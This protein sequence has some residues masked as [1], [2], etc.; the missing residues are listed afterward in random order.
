M[1]PIYNPVED[2]G[3][4]IA[5][6]EHFA[7]LTVW[8]ADPKIIDHLR[9]IGMLVAQR[10]LTHTYPHC[11]RCKNPT[12]FR[13]T[14]QWFISL[15]TDGLR[16]RA[17]EAIRHKVRWVPPWGE[18]RIANMVATRPDWCISRQRVWG[19]PIVAFYC[20]G[21]GA[22]LLEEP[23]IAHV[24]DLMGAGEGADLW[25]TRE[26]KDLVPAGTTCPNCGGSAFRKESDILDV[27]F[28]SG[29]SHA[30]VLETRPD[31]HWPAEM[32]LEGSD[33]HRGWF[34]SS[35]LEAVGTRGAPP[36][37]EV[38]THGFL[39]DGE[40]RKMS[41]SLGNVI[42]PQDVI[43]KHGAE[44]LRLWVAAEDYTED[45]RLPEPE[46]MEQ[47]TEAYRRIR[48]TCRFLLGNLS[49][50][51][52]DHHRMPY[53][54]LEEL[55]RWALGRLGRLIAR[56]RR[57]YEG[58]QFH[59]VYHALSNFCA[60][61][62]S[63]LYLDILKDRLYTFAPNDPRRRAAQTACYEILVAVTRL[64]APILTFTAEE[65][66]GYIH[67]S[68]KPESVHLMTFPEDRGE[69]M[70]EGLEEEWER[71]LEVRREV[72]RA[73]EAG[74]QRKI[75]GSSLEARVFILRAPEEQWMPLLS[76]K[77]TAF[78]KM[79]FIVSDVRL[80]EAPPA[81]P[82]TRYESQDIPELVIEVVKA[83][84]AR[85]WRKC[86]RCWVWSERVG[87]DD[88]HPTLC[89]RCAPVVRAR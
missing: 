27:W 62:L 74:R 85:G 50:F 83:D 1:A 76:A 51:D 26:A 77:G 54:E 23:I 67:G 38:L 52:P 53:G 78:L 29:C 25:Y 73:L 70:D 20:D 16:Q 34:H 19:I 75:V 35:L 3:R 87:E 36:Y 17:L 64:M 80:E 65:V 79:L 41:K 39:V 56:V 6:V 14:E 72:A 21:C 89:E 5:E 44:I 49:D 28:D 68:G 9:A 37:R 66:W 43:S 86:E 63:A 59:Q 81:G 57:A 4:F 12:L 61:D 13:A 7:G 46:I 88:G 22:L 8:D 58:Y 15:D 10:P 32:Y 71:L 33:Q 31:L 48:N 69:W 47:I 2:D 11:W 82:T 84:P 45:I 60:V 42:A 30:A 40:G 55:D 24:A 18:E